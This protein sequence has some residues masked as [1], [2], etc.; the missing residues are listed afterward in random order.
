MNRR[1]FIRNALIST[2]GIFILPGAGRLWHPPGRL[3]QV[4]ERKLSGY[5]LIWDT[6]AYISKWDPIWRSA[7][8][9]RSKWVRFPTSG[10]TEG[11]ILKWT[12]KPTGAE[13]WGA[14]LSEIN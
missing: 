5:P 6:A 9:G 1:S 8:T 13:V 2:S 11:T 10:T 3:L 4:F 7:L 14:L 12:V